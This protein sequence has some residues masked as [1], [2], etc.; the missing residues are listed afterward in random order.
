ME[1]FSARAFYQIG[2]LLDRVRV[3]YAEFTAAG[4][5]AVNGSGVECRI[6]ADRALSLQEFIGDFQALR[7]TRIEDVQPSNR[8]HYQSRAK[9]DQ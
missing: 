5:V 9:S 4:G 1:Q 8:R 7:S 3:E 6:S 2:R